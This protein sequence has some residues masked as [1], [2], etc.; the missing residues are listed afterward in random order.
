M[1]SW[2]NGAHLYR[3]FVIKRCR[4]DALLKKLPVPQIN[5]DSL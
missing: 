5:F 3:Q 2:R 1:D 4:Y